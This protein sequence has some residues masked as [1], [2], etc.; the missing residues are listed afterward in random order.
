MN[1]ANFEELKRAAADL[2][3]EQ[4]IALIAYLKAENRAASKGLTR[5]EIIADTARLRAEGAFDN[6]KSLRGTFANKLPEL[7]FEEIQAI[8]HEASTEWEGE[9]DEF[10]ILP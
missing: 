3:P 7:S 6:N 10:D 4:R 1:A 9:I 8:T 5:E 2:T